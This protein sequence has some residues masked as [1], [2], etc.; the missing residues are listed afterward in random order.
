MLQ[1]QQLTQLLHE[2][3]MKMR[4]LQNPT[5]EA[6][7]VLQEL[8]VANAPETANVFANTNTF[9]NSSI[10]PTNSVF[11]NSGGAGKS[12]F[13][14]QTTPSYSFAVPE[15]K[16]IFGN[17]APST[18]S[19]FAQ[20][21]QQNFASGG[22]IFGGNQIQQQP[23]PS[24]QFPASNIFKSASNSIFGSQ[25]Q[26][27]TTTANHQSPF[28]GAQAA[29]ST[30]NIFMQNNQ[31]PNPFKQ[32]V[33][34]ST[35]GQS[36]FGA[37]LVQQS[38]F[39]T[40]SNQTQPLFPP[41]QTQA[42]FTPSQ[43]AF[44]PNQP[45]STFG[46]T[47]APNQSQTFPPN[48]S[49]PFAAANQSP[50]AAPFTSNTNPTPFASTPPTQ[51]VFPQ[52]QPSF[53]ANQTPFP[54]TATP[55]NQSPFAS[56]TSVQSPFGIGTNQAPF[57]AKP[58]GTITENRSIFAQT[59][60]SGSQNSQ[61][62]ASDHSKSIFGTSQSTIVTPVAVRQ[63]DPTVYSKLETLTENDVKWFEANTFE[64]GKIPDKP[65]TLQMCS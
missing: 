31:P 60:G 18:N 29:Q 35:T 51:S 34:A 26:Q 49:Q 14:N 8:Y 2:A 23:Q 17:V 13:N 20:A 63:D 21:N 36:P 44:T 45:Q 16:S 3:R 54:A 33:P 1:K 22:G 28:G 56:S 11:S 30:S 48:P 10:Q 40:T 25:Q 37:T 27:Q 12:I 42:T 19:I 43:P 59:L 41:N 24:Q 57:A 47:F 38:P 62:S 6:T 46:Q 58:L 53:A 61:T 32:N 39:G 52:T 55:A 50:F 9:G 15:N 7:H 4:S 64:F 65:P 5:A